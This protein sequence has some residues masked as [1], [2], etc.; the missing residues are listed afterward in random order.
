MVEL[1]VKKAAGP[2]KA[3]FDCPFLNSEVGGDGGHRPV[4]F[5]VEQ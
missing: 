3:G 4:V 1:A 5:V 2:V